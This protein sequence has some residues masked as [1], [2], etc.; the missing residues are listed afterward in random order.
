MRKLAMILS[1]F[2]GGVEVRRLG[3]EE[4]GTALDMVV[5]FLSERGRSLR[6]RGA[7]RLASWVREIITGERSAALVAYRD[8]SPV[9][10]VVCGAGP[11]DPWDDRATLGVWFLWVEPEHRGSPKVLASLLRGVR[12]AAVDWETPLVRITLDA[13]QEGL[14]TRYAR[15]LGFTPAESYHSF[16]LDLEES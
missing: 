7:D 11:P 2:F 1:R 8:G 10:Q 16:S 6:P 3:S 15:T 14:A 13:D 9:G 12:Q 5:A 4:L